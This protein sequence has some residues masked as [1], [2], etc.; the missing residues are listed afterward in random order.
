MEEERERKERS[1]LGAHLR[2]FTYS[3][4]NSFTLLRAWS[5]ETVGKGERG[6]GG[7]G[8]GRY[9]IDQAAS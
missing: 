3:G 7:E 6:E 4:A 8:K 2:K 1:K 9:K 5:E